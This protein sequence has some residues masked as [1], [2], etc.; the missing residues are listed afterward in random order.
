MERNKAG[1]MHQTGLYGGTSLA[2]PGWMPLN[3]FEEGVRLGL[4]RLL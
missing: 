4:L 1:Y 2:L 3:A